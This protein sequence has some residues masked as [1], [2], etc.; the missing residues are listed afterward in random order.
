M[1]IYDVFMNKSLNDFLKPT[2][3]TI[4]SFFVFVLGF[5][6]LYY[7]YGFLDTIN[8]FLIGDPVVYRDTYTISAADAWGFGI[9]LQAGF[10]FLLIYI[11][12]SLVSWIFY[13]FKKQK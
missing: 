8:T 11:V 5:F 1:T 6:Y 2:K 4:I 3:I 12:A 13:K 10:S 7:S 9:S